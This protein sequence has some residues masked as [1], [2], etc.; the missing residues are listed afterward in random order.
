M[1]LKDKLIFWTVGLTIFILFTNM[2]SDILLPFV[3]AFIAAYFLDP[4]ADKLENLGASRTTAT[5]TITAGFFIIL[6]FITILLV[7]I[8]YDQFITMINKI[9]AYVAI[10]NEQIIPSF[11]H[12]IERI[13][14][15]AIDKAKEAVTGVS[16][17]V[18]TFLAKM[19]GNIWDSGLAIVNLLSLIFITPV[20]TF[21]ILRDWD[22]I[23]A[24]INGWLPPK[25][26]PTIREQA[27]LVDQ[28]LSGYIRGQTNVCL[29]SGTLYSTGLMFIG[30]DF[31]LFIGMATGILSFIPYV[32][33]MFGV[34][35]GLAIAFFQFG[36]IT[37]LALVAG[38][39]TIVQLLEGSFISPKLVGDKVGLH[40]VWIIFGMLSGAAMFGFTGI[41]I[42]IPVTAIIGVFVRFALA[43]YLESPFY[44]EKKTPVKKKA[45]A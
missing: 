34:I 5:I 20:V 10:F 13:D 25:D 28:T 11:A 4:A 17:Y 37:H 7:P 27:R 9:P 3:V 2:V 12:I 36:D 35:V 29:I 23:I 43:K 18:L 1:Q 8:M 38:V 44:A 6:T 40:P 19:V 21:Y 41:L 15:D 33:M 39:F 22:N 31:G 32:G 14:P 16:G 26:A 30:L 45:K 24:K 42:A